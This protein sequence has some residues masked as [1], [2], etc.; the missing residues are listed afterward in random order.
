MSARPPYWARARRINQIMYP[1]YTD[2]SKHSRW[3]SYRGRP[4]IWSRTPQ[5]SWKA[6]SAHKIWKLNDSRRQRDLPLLGARNRPSQ[7]SSEPSTL[8]WTRTVDRRGRVRWV[9]TPTPPT[10]RYPRLTYNQ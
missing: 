6:R 9:S 1:T 2:H 8:Q 3:S 7:V 10:R 4:A 5:Q